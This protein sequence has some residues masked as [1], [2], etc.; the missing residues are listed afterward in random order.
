M[1]KM[2]PSVSKEAEKASEVT[3]KANKLPCWGT[4]AVGPPKSVPI[5]RRGVVSPVGSEHGNT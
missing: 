3:F 1:S 5:I 4:C 2:S